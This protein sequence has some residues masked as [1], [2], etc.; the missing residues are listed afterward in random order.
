MSESAVAEKRVS[1]RKVRTGIVSSDKMEKTITVLFKSRK[2]HPLYGK[3]MPFTKKL[4]A[5]D[6]KNEAKE[7]DLVEIME[8][9]PL[10]KKKCWRLIKVLERTK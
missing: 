9:R 1:R 8:T 3:M 2:K 4:T 5:H 7:G 10:S 6:E